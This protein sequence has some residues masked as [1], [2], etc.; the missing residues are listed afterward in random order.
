MIHKRTV[1]SVSVTGHVVYV[2]LNEPISTVRH[3][4]NT[5]PDVHINE[6]I[7]VF[8][9]GEGF[10][11]LKECEV[12]KGR[13]CS[14]SLI[15]GDVRLNINGKHFSPVKCQDVNVNDHVVLMFDPGPSTFCDEWVLI[16]EPDFK[17]YEIPF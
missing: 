2:E 8:D 11:L 13:V 12:V 10:T 6:E 16:D 4:K 15:N 5:L 7:Y 3:L 9:D 14:V 1:K 17:P